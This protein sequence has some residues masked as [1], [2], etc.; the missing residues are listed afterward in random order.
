MSGRKAREPV[1]LS[2]CVSHPI[3]SSSLQCPHM[4]SHHGHLCGGE[5]QLGEGGIWGSQP[6]G[7]VLLHQREHKGTMQS[8]VGCRGSFLEQQ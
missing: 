8:Q 5:K 6:A 4:Y 2:P 1:L 7:L 3:L